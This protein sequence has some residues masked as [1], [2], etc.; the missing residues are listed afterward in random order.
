MRETDDIRIEHPA[1]GAAVVVFSGEHDLSTRSDLEELIASLIRENRV[2][3]ADL[4]GA[5]FVDSTIIN[6]LV[7]A[8]RDASEQDCM[9]RLQMGT[10]AIVRRIFEVTGVLDLLD[11]APTREEALGESSR[12]SSQPH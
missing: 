6:L 3:V 8:K 12:R 4:S 1:A 5:E 2:V 10:Q 9:F 7:Q 11:C